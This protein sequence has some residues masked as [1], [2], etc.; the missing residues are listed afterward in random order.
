MGQ[1][2]PKTITESGAI[3][4][5]KGKL[6][7]FVFVSS[8]GAGALAFTDDTDGSGDVVLSA[9]VLDGDTKILYLGEDFILFGTG[10]YATI[11]TAGSCALTA[12]YE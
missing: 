12:F 5:G 1:V 9:T 7:G 6:R 11:T 3:K 2:K 4:S 8:S 10:I